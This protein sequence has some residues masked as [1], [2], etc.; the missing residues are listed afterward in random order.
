MSGTLTQKDDDGK[1]RA[2][3]YFSRRLSPAEENYSANDRELLAMIYFLKRFRCYL[4][5]S[6]FEL[7][8]DNQV[9]KNFFTKPILSRREARWLD[10]LGHFGITELTLKPGKAHVLGDAPS[11]IPHVDLEKVLEVSNTQILSVMLPSDFASN[12]AKDAV[13]GPILNSLLGRKAKSD[14]EEARMQQLRSEFK[15]RD[16]KL[17]YGEKLCVP[18]RNVR[19]VLRLA[20][21][22]ATAGNFGF[23]KT[24]QRLQRFHWRHKT[25]DIQKYCDGCVSCQQS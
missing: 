4:E 6:I 21:D 3:A 9:L 13:F 23:H 7:I 12:Y 2:I 25:R 1:E 16:G 10:L 20:H 19:D 18:R 24:L 15:L 5:G 17:F 22:C 8:T 14:T 11:R